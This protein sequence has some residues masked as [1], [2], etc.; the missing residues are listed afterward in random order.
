MTQIP[1]DVPVVLRQ[2]IFTDNSPDTFYAWGGFVDK[3]P[4]P[5]EVFKFK[6]D[7]RGGG[8]WSTDG[9][10]P[11]LTRY[12]GGACVSAPRSGFC[13][14]GIEEPTTSDFKHGDF[15]S[16]FL[17]VNYTS[18]ERVWIQHANAP[19]SEFGTVYGGTAHHVPSFRPDGLVVIFGGNHLDPDIDQTPNRDMDKLW[20]MD[21]ATPD[22]WHVQQITGGPPAR[23]RWPCV[24]GAQGRNH[25][26]EIFMFG[27]NDDNQA[28][29]DVWILSLPGFFWM[30]AKYN[31]NSPRAQMSCVVAGQRQMIVVGG[32]SRKGLYENDTFPQGLGI[33]DLTELEWKDNFNPAAAA[34]DSPPSVKSWY[35][36]G[37]YDP[38]VERFLNLSHSPSPADNSLSPG[39]MGG[40]VGGSILGAALIGLVVFLLM[41]RRQKKKKQALRSGGEAENAA[42]K[43]SGSSWAPTSTT[44][45]PSELR[46]GISEVGGRVPSYTTAELPAEHGTSEVGGRVPSYIAAELHINHTPIE[47]DAQEPRSR[48]A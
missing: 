34:Y 21:P 28:F 48:A 13:L 22:Q 10:G 6:A 9:I 7:G 5:E 29:D 14:G 8:S 15:V 18:P 42:R 36:D 12:H 46:P 16:G 24:V 11:R 40:A 33:F 27:G 32:V 37:Q 23:R 35:Y 17:Q 4:S 20:F 43:P 47:L 45:K 2:N 26:Y 3:E 30:E 44:F 19:Y 1:K 41:R 39:A 25:T 31:G 38:G